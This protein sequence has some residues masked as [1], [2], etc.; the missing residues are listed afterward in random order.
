M[1]NPCDP[2]VQQQRQDFLDWLYAC[3]GR[4]EA[5][6]YTY[7]GLYAEL[8][9]EAA[10]MDPSAAPLTLTGFDQVKHPNFGGFSQ[11]IQVGLA[12]V[13]LAGH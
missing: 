1:V 9:S 3:S 4:H 7:T 6:D 13:A 2:A 12:P 10:G 5:G 8:R 11:R